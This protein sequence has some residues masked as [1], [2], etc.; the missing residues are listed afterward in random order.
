[1]RAVALCCLYAAAVSLKPKQSML[2]LKTQLD[3]HCAKGLT[4][5]EMTVCCQGDCGEC[6]DNSNLCADANSGR[7]TTCCPATILAASPPSCDNSMAP[8]AISESVR[9]PEEH[10]MPAVHAANDCGEAKKDMKDLIDLNTH[11]LSFPDKKL[12]PG[13]TSDCGSYGTT[14]QAAAACSNKD[15]CVGFTV[16]SDAPDCLLIAGDELETLGDESGTTTYVKK[17]DGY[18]G[19]AYTLIPGQVSEACSVSCGGGYLHVEAG[20]KSDSGVKVKTGMCSALVLMNADAVPKT[21]FECNT[22]ECDAVSY[23]DMC[24]HMGWISRLPNYYYAPWQWYWW[25]GM[26]LTGSYSGVWAGINDKGWSAWF[27]LDG[28]WSETNN[29]GS[30]SYYGFEWKATIEAKCGDSLKMFSKQSATKAGNWPWAD[31]WTYYSEDLM[32][33][34]VTIE[35]PCMCE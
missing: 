8:C 23:H 12:S 9:N 24:G 11:Y 13:S 20:C 32:D 35:A 31:Q 26:E 18:T 7:A 25:Q 16:K 28:N 2:H 27:A 29:V 21:E 10:V 3:P 4:N 33:I 15:D 17:E 19:H 30:Q 1:M 6:S 22:F 14:A 34:I 5:T